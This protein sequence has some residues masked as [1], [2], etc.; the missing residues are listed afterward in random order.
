MKPPGPFSPEG[1]AP[2]L[3]RGVVTRIGP[4]FSLTP[5]LDA[6]GS[7]TVAIDPS[8]TAVLYTGFE[9]TNGNTTKENGLYRTRDGG[10]TWT[11]LGTSDENPW[12]CT[13]N[14]LDLA[15]NMAVD[16]NDPNHL[17]VT[18]GVRGGA[19]G[20]WVSWDAGETWTRAFFDDLTA[21]SVDPCD[22]CHV[23]LGS[24][25]QGPIGVLETEDGG[26]SWK[27]H[28][29]PA[30]FDN[31]GGSYGVAFLYDPRSG[32]GDPN[33]WML[34]GNGIWRTSNAGDS[35]SR[36]SEFGGIHGST[37]LYYATN[38]DVYTGSYGY[39]ARSR[40]NGMTWELSQAGLSNGTYFGVGG[41]GTNLYTMVDGFP[42]PFP[43]MMAPESAG[44]NWTPLAADAKTPRGISHQQFDPSSGVMY[45]VG[46][47]GP[48]GVRLAD[49]L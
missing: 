14:F 12:D 43:I 30:G 26:Y 21:M 39:P 24:H 25:T 2:R 38:G 17:Y 48:Y 6:I 16:P 10:S 40:D 41:D 5:P 32:Q 23:I 11:L 49:P 31:G 27:I 18:Q 37:L 46:G 4:E 3:E 36:V 29:P 42:A 45:F 19:L 13:S 33:T 15:I 22:F 7:A 9:V 8:N 47:D 34:H 35:W 44:D 28:E 1:T 20:F